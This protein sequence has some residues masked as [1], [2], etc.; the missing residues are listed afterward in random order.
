MCLRFSGFSHALKTHDTCTWFSDISHVRSIISSFDE[1]LHLNRTLVIMIQTSLFPG[2]SARRSHVF[3]VTPGK[4]FSWHHV[5]GA[6]SSAGEHIRELCLLG[7]ASIQHVR[8]WSRKQ[9]SVASL[10]KVNYEEDRGL[11]RF[12]DTADKK[13]HQDS[14]HE[15]GQHRTRRPNTQ[16]QWTPSPALSHFQCEKRS[17]VHIII[18][19]N[20]LFM[21]SL[22][23]E[24]SAVV[25]PEH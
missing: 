6:K 2:W 1:L 12:L 9:E 14:P 15:V 3:Q 16:K 24:R 23:Q 25:S 5:S 11:D 21:L 4:H 19:F 13:E 8:L 17:C 7:N 10:D 20:S 18:H 22:T